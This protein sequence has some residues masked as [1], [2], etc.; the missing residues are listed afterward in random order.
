[1]KVEEFT[2]SGGIDVMRT[3]KTCGVERN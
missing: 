3:I 1:M 2:G